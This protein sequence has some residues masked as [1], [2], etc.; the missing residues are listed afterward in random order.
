MA[1]F[2]G[3]LYEIFETFQSAQNNFSILF[4]ASTYM[5]GTLHRAA[6]EP[7]ANV[8]YHD[9]FHRVTATIY[10]LPHLLIVCNGSP[11]PFAHTLQAARANQSSQECLTQLERVPK[12]L[13]Q[14][15]LFPF[16]EESHWATLGSTLLLSCAKIIAHSGN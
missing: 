9:Q 8:E 2:E 15:H 12:L 11:H 4:V 14:M 13:N 1:Y 3:D 7:S 5:H 16:S 6:I 10:S